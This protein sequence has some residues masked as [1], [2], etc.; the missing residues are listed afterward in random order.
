M[1][2]EVLCMSF[3]SIEQDEAL[4][5]EERKALVDKSLAEYREAV[6]ALFATASP[7]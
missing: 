5:P 7:E 2:N 4:A 1:Y 3:R 6:A